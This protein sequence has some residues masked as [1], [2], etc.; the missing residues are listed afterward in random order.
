MPKSRPMKNKMRAKRSAKKSYG[1]K[2][3]PKKSGQRSNAA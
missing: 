2:R 3:K 1:M